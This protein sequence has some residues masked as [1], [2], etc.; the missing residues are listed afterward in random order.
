MTG[1][2][3]A[4]AVWTALQSAGGAPA[5]SP[6]RLVRL[7]PGCTATWL[8]DAPAAS[9]LQVATGARALVAADGAARA[10]VA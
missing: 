1:G 6:A 4:E 7:G 9:Q 8:M 10:M 5:D 3:K 2:N